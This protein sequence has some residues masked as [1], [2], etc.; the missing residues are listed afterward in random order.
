MH[1]IADAVA[2]ILLAAIAMSVLRAVGLAVG[3][4]PDDG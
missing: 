1:M 4:W 3:G 2:S